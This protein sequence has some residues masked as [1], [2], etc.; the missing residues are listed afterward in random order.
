MYTPL[1]LRCAFF[2]ESPK[3]RF[4]PN[5]KWIFAV[6]NRLCIIVPPTLCS[7]FKKVP[8]TPAITG[9]S[10]NSPIYEKAHLGV[11]YRW[12]N[13]MD[14]LFGLHV[15]PLVKEISSS[16]PINNLNNY[17]NGTHEIIVGFQIW[18]G[19]TAP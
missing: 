13:P 15:S 3:Q 12:D 17:K 4:I 10:A 14:T 1:K 2:T 11:S 9:L 7:F 5:L 8:G 16:K 6:V 18:N 19:D